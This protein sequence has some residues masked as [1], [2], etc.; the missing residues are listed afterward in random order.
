MD[1]SKSKAKTAANECPKKPGAGSSAATMH[2][3][4][5]ESLAQFV[6]DKLAPEEIP[7]SSIRILR[8]VVSLRKQSARFF[9]R[10]AQKSKD[11]KLEKSNVTHGFII[12]VL[13]SILARFGAAVATVSRA[14]SN[15]V[16]Q[17]SYDQIDAND[18]N[19]MFEHLKVE[20]PPDL[21]EQDVDAALESE[22]P[23]EKQP[24]KAQKK[25]GKKK[26]KKKPSKEQRVQEETQDIPETFR[27]EES[28]WAFMLGA[29]EEGDDYYMIIYCFFRD[30]NT[31]RDYVVD[32]W[33][34]YFYFKSHP[35]D[36]LAVMTNAA[37]E[38]FHEMESELEAS[39]KHCR[40]GMADYEFMMQA[41]FFECGLDH[42]DYEGDDELTEEEETD[43]MFKEAD[44]LGFNV[45]TIVETIIKKTTPGNV[46][47]KSYS[48]SIF[49]LRLAWL[50]F[51]ASSRQIESNVLLYR[52]QYI[53]G[54]LG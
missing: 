10:V 11:D 36:N 21:D 30:F 29:G 50:C 33:V 44:W 49:F 22:R 32:R 8:D 23:P 17:S 20:Q 28:P 19:N 51:T 12:K 43:K 52:I 34:E 1:L 2:W 40:R 18:L 4:R 46:P 15:S 42:V 48:N 35:I 38:M 14:P 26:N 39:L 25:N 54:I 53:H 13:E 3:S 27:I 45:Y 6:I 24:K 9:T 37:Y 41:L 16:K 5:L 7:Q 47:R 31:V